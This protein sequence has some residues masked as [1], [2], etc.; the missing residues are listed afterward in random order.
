MVAAVVPGP[1][2]AQHLAAEAVLVVLAAETIGVFREGAVAG[3]LETVG[4]GAQADDGA[5]AVEIGNEVVHLLLGPV[6]ETGENDHQVRF[7]HL[8]DAG[9]VVGS[10][11]DLSLGV[12]AENDGAFE[13]V[14]FC[15]DPCQG[16][17]GL[18]GAVL[19]I[20]GDEDEVLALAGTAVA[21]IDEGRIGFEQLAGGKETDGEQ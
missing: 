10:R 21:F 1:F 19:M 7:F 13:A 5:G 8:F 20:A 16:G 14:A 6:L 3:D 9:Y 4:G 15:Q 12:H 2:F 17:K 11:L 18:F